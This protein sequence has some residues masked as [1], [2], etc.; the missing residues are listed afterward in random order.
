M[1]DE[2]VKEVRSCDI[3]FKNSNS[4]LHTLKKL[5]LD[6]I[7][8]NY[9][10]I[11]QAGGYFNARP[12]KKYTFKWILAK[13]M[14]APKE[15]KNAYVRDLTKWRKSVSE[16][17][18]SLLDEYESIQSKVWFEFTYNFK[19]GKLPHDFDQ[20]I[21]RILPI[22][23]VK[24]MKLMKPSQWF[25]FWYSNPCVLKRIPFI[26]NADVMLTF[27]NFLDKNPS[28]ITHLYIT[29]QDDFKSTFSKIL[30]KGKETLSFLE[31]KIVE[32]LETDN[33]ILDYIVQSKCQ[34]EEVKIKKDLNDLKFDRK[35]IIRLLDA[36][37]NSTE[38]LDLSNWLKNI[39]Q[40]KN[41]MVELFRIISQMKNLKR[42]NLLAPSNTEDDILAILSS[43]DSNLTQLE[44]LTFEDRR[45]LKFEIDNIVAFLLK[46][47]HSL[48]TI[49]LTEWTNEQ[50][51]DD[52]IEFLLQVISKMKNLKE[53][54]MYAN[55]LID[56]RP[57]MEKYHRLSYFVGMEDMELNVSGY[58]NANYSGDVSYFSIYNIAIF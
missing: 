12:D 4:N 57:N 8:R 22:D 36:Q 54:K 45:D 21:R 18:Q 55:D 31:V 28:K 27:K 24:T 7:F 16:L 25:N 56:L 53:L 52:M 2:E 29:Y 41:K 33:D 46:H 14:P 48:K 44:E 10:H 15:E 32:D 49:D 13:V 50:Y 30:K 42:L 39:E 23:V 34:L 11:S 38:T 3:L 26:P 37:K 43:D 9:C 20:A 51:D 35:N 47:G 1:A 58:R 5:C 19:D 6:Q 17:P 40:D